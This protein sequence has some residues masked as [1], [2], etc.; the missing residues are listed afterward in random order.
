MDTIYLHVML[1]DLQ[2]INLLGISL[3]EA[4]NNSKA[5][6]EHE[7]VLNGIIIMKDLQKR[8]DATEYQL[9]KL[10]LDDNIVIEDLRSELRRLTSKY[11]LLEQQNAAINHDLKRENVFFSNEKATIL[12]EWDF[13][14]NS[15]RSEKTVQ[16]A[17]RNIMYDENLEKV[18]SE[19]TDTKKKN[20]DLNEHLTKL[21]NEVR[22]LQTA[23]SQSLE[24]RS[25][26]KNRIQ[27]QTAQSESWEKQLFEMKQVQARKITRILSENAQLEETVTSLRAQL[28]NIEKKNLISQWEHK[29]ENSLMNKLNRVQRELHLS[30]QKVERTRKELATECK[31]GANEKIDS[32]VHGF[33][34]DIRVL[35]AK[36]TKAQKQLEDEQKATRETTKLYRENQQV[37]ERKSENLK[38][39]MVSL[40]ICR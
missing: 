32:I 33:E 31:T 21:K 16:F 20:L 18:L 10:K 34:Q 19:L 40:I 5:N 39:K 12:G 17:R 24:E 37:N 29:S 22:L 38:D 28:E 3:L 6:V 25:I 1:F 30:K 15:L 36:L 35:H 27:E 9:N 11:L 2:Q 23:Q 8:L 7:Q 4:K 14:T 13:D 26:Y